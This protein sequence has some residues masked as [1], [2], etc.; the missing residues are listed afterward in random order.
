[1]RDGAGAVDA[2]VGH[3]P[4][5]R[6]AASR[7]ALVVPPGTK[8]DGVDHTAILSLLY[9]KSLFDLWAHSIIS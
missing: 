5:V 7:H 4:D 9:S 3:G 8:G 1:M 2:G 6:P